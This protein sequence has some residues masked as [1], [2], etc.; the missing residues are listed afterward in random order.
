MF[1]KRIALLIVGVLSAGTAA[2]QV[3]ESIF[4]GITRREIGPAI[5]SGRVSDLAVYEDDPSIFY[6]ASASGGLLKTINGGASW[7]NVFDSQPTVSIGDV[8]INPTD[9]NVV[10]VGTGEANNRQSSSWGDG[11]YKSSDG[12]KTWKH[13]GL[14][15]SQHIGR[16]VI[17]PQDTDIIYVAALGRLWGANKERGVFKTSDGGITWQHVLA[18]NENTGAVDLIMDPANP[19][20]IYAAAYQRRRTGWG[21][22]GGGKD[23]GIY[24]T[25]DAG[26]TWRK[27]TAGLPEGDTG[28]IGLDIYRRN[29]NIVYA[30]V[31]HRE[32]GVFRSE[33][34]GESWIKV[35][36]LNPRPMY[37][38]QIRID[39]N[40]SQRIYVNGT[41]LHISDDGGK[42]FRDDGAAVVHLDHHAM[43]IDPRNSRHIINGND[44]GPWVSRDRALTWEHLNNYPIGQFYNVTVDMQQPYHIYGGMQD[45]A[46]WGGPSSVRSRQGIA[47]EHW[48]QMLACDGMFT[49]VDPTDGDTIYT[50]CQNGRIV[51]YD[52]KTGERKMI[53]PQPEEGQPQSR[54][55][56]TAPIVVS[57]HDGKT[58]Y[59]GGDKVFKSTDRGQRW[60]VISPDLTM[61]LDREE[62]V[63]MGVSGRDITV[64]K[65]DGMSSFGNITALAESPRRAG[66]LYAG[67]DDGNLQVSRD[68]GATWQNMTSRIAGVPKLIYVSR[69]TPSAFADGTVYASF[70]GHRS[71]DFKPYVYMS[72]DFG[73]TWRSITNNLPAG[74]VYVIK[75]DPKNQNLLYVGTEVG[76]FVSTNRGANWTRWKGMPTVAVYDLVVHPRDNDLVLGTHGRSFIVFDDIS[77]LQQLT[78]EVLAS[79]SHLF[80]IGPAIQYIPNEDGWFLGGR[81]YRAPNRE[82]GAFL[83][84]YLRSAAKD[85]VAIAISDA[86][87]KVVRQLKGPKTAGLHRVA[88]D[89]RDEPSGPASTG[90]AGALVLT[91]LGPFVPPGDY[92][93]QLTAD[94]RTLTKTVKVGG[95]PHVE[96]SDADRQTL[97]RTLLT[98][99]D[100]QRTVGSA[101]DAVTRLDQRLQQIAET[102]KAYPNAPATVKTSAA[103][104]TKQ[105]TELRTAISGAGGGRGGGGF[106]GGP[107]PLRNRINS[108]KSEV[109]GS[110]SLPTQVQSAQVP[111]F[112]K[113]LGDLVDRVNNVIMT[114]LPSLYKQLH[115]N[116]IYPSVGEPI[117]LVRADGTAAAH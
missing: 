20:V 93:V 109:V 83:N 37:F 61:H 73:E 98:L 3:P 113:Q 68:S 5:M 62:L 80:D 76:L 79:P 67:T 116:S 38:S 28:R 103:T 15:E 41:N 77:P 95:D 39:P 26:R 2:A 23:S 69:V 72:T 35:N 104:L 70:D 40:D 89:L 115:E 106:G 4:D 60:T 48:Y 114:A 66:L 36:S 107:Q 8:A 111:V 74:S 16:I 94:G 105:V 6:V 10:W 9:P 75:E 27:L 86:S 44:G 25:V 100:M 33:D 91:N 31:E 55:N 13:M 88:W 63:I 17:D 50:N 81:S 84:Y 99:T 110:Q 19:K 34:K 46:S 18:I 32:G 64:A 7:T 29:S 11:V 71:D 45:N 57:P 42:T 85:D 51:R 101:A 59:T 112:R 102:L 108:L 56:W 90:L 52:R 54:W 47:N 24:K 21:F 58:L 22:N 12:G 30:T 97:Y 14:R 43:W 49:V 65:N 92:R 82:L 96:M 87:G 53:M 78:A 1:S 117:K